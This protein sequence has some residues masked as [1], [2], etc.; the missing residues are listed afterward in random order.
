LYLDDCRYLRGHELCVGGQSPRLLVASDAA[1]TAAVFELTN[2][3]LVV[4]G[5][6]RVA[7]QSLRLRVERRML[8]NAMVERIT[9]RSHARDPVPFELELRLDADFRSM[10]EV[11]GLVS[12]VMREMRRHARGDTL[13]FAAVGVDGRERSTT[14]TCPGA[15][16]EDD[17][18]LRVLVSLDPGQ[19]R[20]LDVR[21]TLARRDAHISADVA[22]IEQHD[23][24]ASMTQAGAEADAWLADRPRIEVDYELI[25][26]VLRRSLL[27]VRLLASDLDG[28]RYYAAGVPVVRDPLRARQHHHRAGDARRRPRD[29]AADDPPA[30]QAAGHTRRR[31]PRR[32]ARQGAARAALRRAGRP[33]PDAAGALLRDRRCH[34][35]VPLPAVEARRLDRLAGPVS[36]A[37]CPGRAGAALD[38]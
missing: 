14:V 34:P 19:E 15:V 36:G 3:E 13:V 31:R 26:R 22:V 35:A 12:P 7:L 28:Q 2:P 9:L 37:A 23:G 30:G 8:P 33:R 17:G 18:R 24:R 21:F 20:T 4:A 6:R 25:D 27:D 32:G 1:G 11:R 5:G 10:L 38:R 16:A 29:G